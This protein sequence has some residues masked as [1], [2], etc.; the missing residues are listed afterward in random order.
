MRTSGEC[1]RPAVAMMD[2]ASDVL[3]WYH[4][5]GL[6]SVVAL[7]KWNSGLL[8]REVVEWYAY[9]AFCRTRIFDAAGGELTQS[10]QSTTK[11]CTGHL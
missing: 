2:V 9:D 1:V 10:S 5:D 7:S 11:K 4:I 6:G 3:Y 8:Q